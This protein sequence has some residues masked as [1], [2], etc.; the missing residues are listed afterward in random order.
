LD[1]IE[2][3]IQLGPPSHALYRDAA[4][5]YGRAADLR[6]TPVMLDAPI[7]T[8]LF[9]EARPRRIERALFY[10]RES[11]V[12]GQYPRQF[13]LFKN[14]VPPSTLSELVGMKQLITPSTNPRLIEPAGELD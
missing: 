4:L 5:L 14:L 9:L 13:I 10:A 11:I 3:A 2:R 12:L 6:R 7:A 1:D 8:A